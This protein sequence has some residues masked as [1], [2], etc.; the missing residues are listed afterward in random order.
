[1][2]GN[3]RKRILSCIVI[4]LGVAFF[5]L[6]C[7]A[8]GCSLKGCSAQTTETT[9]TTIGV[10]TPTP[11]PPPSI[12][13]EDAS[14]Y[15]DE[16]LL[17]IYGQ[18]RGFK[19]TSTKID[20]EPRVEAT[21]IFDAVTYNVSPEG[22]DGI[23]E[24]IL[25]NPIYLSGVDQAL[26]ECKIVGQSDWSNKFRASYEPVTTEWWEQWIE[27]DAATGKWYVT[28]EYHLI[29]ARYCCIV[30]G[31]Q[32]LREVDKAK[33][34]VHFPLNVEMEVC[35]RSENDDKYPFWVYRFI[36]KDG[37]EI[38]IGINQID[39]RWAIIDPIPTPTPTTKPPTP[40]PTTTEPPT[41][42]LT[43]KPPTPTPVTQ[44]KRPQNDPINRN[45]DPGA[46]ADIGT[47]SDPANHDNQTTETPEPTSPSSYTNQ[48][49][50]TPKPTT[51][52]SATATPKPTAAPTAPPPKPTGSSN[53]G[54]SGRSN[55][56]QSDDTPTQEPGT[57]NDGVNHG[58]A[59][60]GDPD[61]K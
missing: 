42:T 14:S 44:P 8:I 2:E 46:A 13:E 45:T 34:S 22:L 56:T 25:S 43:T 10:A 7:I 21:K 53:S 6:L 50:P 36:F 35:Y 28:K 59:D 24:E 32:Y 19:R 20:V 39:Y 12:S 33:V 3:R 23:V 47:P 57:R 31:L 37:R 16:Q 5:A 51:A 48:A 58:D 4:V 52:S 61:D 41:P 18:P 15:T 40:T 1:M 49:T 17:S 11:T 60:Y 9:E 27:K 54:G 38:Y 29:A 55:S 30:K 26:R